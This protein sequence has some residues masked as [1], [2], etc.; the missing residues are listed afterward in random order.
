M[1]KMKSEQSIDELKNVL[2]R[3]DGQQIEASKLKGR[4]RDNSENLTRGYMR[5]KRLLN[6]LEI[7]YQGTSLGTAIIRQQ[8]AADKMRYAAESNRERMEGGFTGYQQRL[9]TR[10][11][12]KKFFQESHVQV[13]QLIKA[14]NEELKNACSQFQSGVG[15]E[16]LCEDD[17]IAERDMYQAAVA[18]WDGYIGE[19]FEIICSADSL[20]DVLGIVDNYN[21][22]KDAWN[23]NKS[24][25][26][27]AEKK[28][29]ELYDKNAGTADSFSFANDLQASITGVISDLANAWLDKGGFTDV[30]KG[31]WFKRLNNQVYYA[32]EIKANIASIDKNGNIV[33]D[34]DKLIGQIKAENPN[35]SSS[36]LAKIE[37]FMKKNPQ[38]A[39]QSADD[40]LKYIQ[41]GLREIPGMTVEAG[42]IL[43]EKLASVYEGQSA[44]LSEN[45][46]AMLNY[47][48][49]TAQY[50]DDLAKAASAAQAGRQF[51]SAARVLP[52]VGT[53]LD[54]G[55]ASCSR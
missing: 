8:E 30:T 50:V 3:I 45:A 29:Q 13:L 5:I 53:A 37:Q 2:S 15:S 11:G 25:L 38:Q 26:N 28:L 52:I 10:E 54:F 19:L 12:N 44:W 36:E 41:K 40:Y 18:D 49:D 22:A 4:L 6:D 7:K 48:G 43:L 35:L 14:A 42:K 51:A 31:K 27:A 17:L 47:T 39:D 1:Q 34:A 23:E 55:N 33:Y 24:Y 21:G 20:M 16:D 32:E 46:A 9:R